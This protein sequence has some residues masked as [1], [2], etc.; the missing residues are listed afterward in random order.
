MTVWKEIAGD[1]WDGQF[2][3]VSD[4]G[5]VRLVKLL[6]QGRQHS[7]APRVMLRKANGSYQPKKVD[8]LVATSFDLD[9]G[10]IKRIIH[11]DGDP[12]NNSKEN[13]K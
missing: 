1:W 12:S 13:L 2:Y 10:D 8:E 11:K 7:P 4:Q 6:T 9:V 5:D 3:E